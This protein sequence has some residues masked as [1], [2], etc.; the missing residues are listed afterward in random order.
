[1]TVSD[2]FDLS[3]EVAIVAGGAGLLGSRVVAGL[4]DHGCEVV[5]ADIDA[6][7]GEAVSS[8]VGKAASYREV[9]LTD[10]EQTDEMVRGTIEEHGGVDI[11][12]NAAY[13]TTGGYGRSYEEVTVEGWREAVLNHM[14]SY[15]VPIKSVSPVMVERGGGCIVNF[16][17]IYGMQ[18]PSFPIYDGTD[19]GNP[20]EYAAIKGGILNLTRYLASYLGR[21][22]VRVNAVSPGGVFDDQDPSFVDRYERRTPLGRM[23]TPEDVVGAVV[24]LTS[25]AGSYVTGHNLVVDGGWTI[26]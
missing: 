14:D 3:G 17:S 26:V 6:E 23:A 4:C 5:I 2:R 15:F 12:V 18:G 22:G 9:D 8:N 20:V 13:P 16:T 1:M 7:R 21:D 25:P 19:L 11:L 24:Y 10:V